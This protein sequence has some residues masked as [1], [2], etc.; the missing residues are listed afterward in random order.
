MYSII[1]QKAK[2]VEAP[3]PTGALKA[4]KNIKLPILIVHGNADDFV[5]TYMGHQLYEACGSSDKNL[6]IVENAAHARSIV[7]DPISYD[8]EVSKLTDKY[9]K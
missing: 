7:L 9:I 8:R 6:L 5:P 1:E 4:V 2:L 3:N